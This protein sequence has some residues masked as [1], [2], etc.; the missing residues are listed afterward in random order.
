M[1]AKPRQKQEEM[2]AA[3]I[4]MIGEDLLHNILSKLPAVECAAAACVSRS[5][6][7]IITRLL[8]LPNLSSSLSRNPNLQ[9]AVNEVVEKVLARTIRPQFVI[10]SIGPSFDLQ[11]AHRLV[12]D[13]SLTLSLYIVM[14]LNAIYYKLEHDNR[15]RM[16][17]EKLFLL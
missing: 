9:C 2:A 11:E 13:L 14:K 7:L 10:A 15:D 1:A 4:D 8:S 6:N 3:T 12:C 5:W 16:K 17:E